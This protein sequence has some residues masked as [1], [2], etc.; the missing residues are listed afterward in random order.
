MIAVII[1]ATINV[2]KET[3]TILIL[4]GVNVTMT[5][6]VEWFH[7]CI[8]LESYHLFIWIDPDCAA[9]RKHWDVLNLFRDR[10]NYGSTDQRLRGNPRILLARSWHDL[11]HGQ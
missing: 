10:E 2:I 8:A 5:G 11:S 4:V 7:P 9:L 1:F 6:G 3:I